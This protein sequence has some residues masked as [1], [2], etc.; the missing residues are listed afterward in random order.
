MSC[1]KSNYGGETNAEMKVSSSCIYSIVT[2]RAQKIL[3][4]AGSS[5]FIDV[6]SL[7]SLKSLKLIKFPTL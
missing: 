4:A 1:F 5:S 6:L 7:D 3:V 2:N